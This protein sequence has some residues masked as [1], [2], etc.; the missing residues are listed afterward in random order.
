MKKDKSN[1]RGRVT[2]K[3]ECIKQNTIW[4][5]KS[6]DIKMKKTSYKQRWVTNKLKRIDK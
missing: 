1:K 5:K 6:K 2:G 4:N 3:T